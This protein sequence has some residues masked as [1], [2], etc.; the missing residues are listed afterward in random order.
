MSVIVE[1]RAGEGGADAKSLVGEQ[2]TMYQKLA[3]RRSL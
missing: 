1:I 2:Y 3:A